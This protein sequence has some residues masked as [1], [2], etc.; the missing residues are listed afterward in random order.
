L[1]KVDY[2][3]DTSGSTTKNLKEAVL[4]FYMGFNA[5]PNQSLLEVKALTSRVAS[6]E[7]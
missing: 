7:I 1:I 2:P 5:Q 3:L 6:L 4:D